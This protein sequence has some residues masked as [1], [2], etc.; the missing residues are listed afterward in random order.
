MKTFIQFIN[1]GVYDVLIPKS[2]EEIKKHLGNEG[3]VDQ[4][5]KVMKYGYNIFDMIPNLT[6]EDIINDFYKYDNMIFLVEDIESLKDYNLISFFDI[7]E[8][9]KNLSPIMKLS[10]Y[11]EIDSDYYGSVKKFAKNYLDLSR[12]DVLK[13]FNELKPEDKIR[14]AYIYKKTYYNILTEDQWYDVFNSLDSK[15]KSDVILQYYK[16]G[17]FSDNLI[18]KILKNDNELIK[19]LSKESSDDIGNLISQDKMIKEKKY[20]RGYMTY[21]ILD[22]IDKSPN[23][24][25]RRK[26]I[27]KFVFDLKYGDSI[28]NF[29]PSKNSGYYSD[30]FTVNGYGNLKKTTDA[31]NPHKNV[32]WSLSEDGKEK[33]KWYRKKFKDYKYES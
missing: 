31:N 27:I 3:V 19:I 32:R 33:L 12:D 1:E 30:F 15:T 8:I 25:A 18:M 29:D 10:I 2:K 17:P 28:I 23:K 22:F 5:K 7:K 26:D 20:P 24:E 4:I 6:R 9:A 11:S 16:Y 14:L 13:M 21:R